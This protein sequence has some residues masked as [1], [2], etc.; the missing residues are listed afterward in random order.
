M[1]CIDRTPLIHG[2][3][4]NGELIFYEK[5]FKEDFQESFVLGTNS[6]DG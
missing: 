5:D 2:E 1:S 6:N 3:G 4:F